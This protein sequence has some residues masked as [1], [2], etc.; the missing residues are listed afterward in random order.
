MLITKNKKNYASIVEF[1]EGQPM[2]NKLDVK[3]LQITKSSTN[4]IASQIFKD[5]LENKILKVEGSPNVIE[6][7]TDVENFESEIRRSLNDGESTYLKPTNVK[8]PLAYKDPLSNGGFRGAMVWNAVYP[9]KEIN[10]PD[11]FFL[12][13]TTLTRKQDLEKVEDEEIKRILNET[14]F[15]ADDKRIKTKGVYIVA[16]PRDEQIPDWLKPFIDEEQIV[17]DTMKAFLPVMNSLGMETIYTAS[18][19]ENISSYI[20]L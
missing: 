18:G 9:E 7:L 11:S 6:I 2:H 10:F 1:K 15:E 20:E 19:A 17:Q 5:I 13:K 3:G 16:I 8:D 4:R 14:I 12:V